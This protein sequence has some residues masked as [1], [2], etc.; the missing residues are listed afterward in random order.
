[1]ETYSSWLKNRSNKRNVKL[2]AR[3]DTPIFIRREKC[4]SKLENT[5]QARGTKYLILQETW[6]ATRD[7][8]WFSH[9]SSKHLQVA[10]LWAIKHADAQGLLWGEH[11]IYTT[12]V[13]LRMFSPVPSEASMDGRWVNV[14][15]VL[16]DSKVVIRNTKPAFQSLP[17]PWA[18]IEWPRALKQLR[19]EGRP[20]LLLWATY[21]EGSGLPNPGTV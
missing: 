16:W 19:A 10:C 17:V 20:T 12:V 3:R 6:T 13:H 2:K 14:A 21:L 5:W 15:A 8:T 11:F 4:I 18:E 7:V 9:C 1:M